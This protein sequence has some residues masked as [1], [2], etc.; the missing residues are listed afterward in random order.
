[1]SKIL[2]NFVHANGFPAGSYQTLFNY[3]PVEYKVIA[4]KVVIILN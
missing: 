1:M 3:L 4:K 2:V